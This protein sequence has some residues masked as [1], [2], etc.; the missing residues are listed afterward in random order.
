MSLAEILKWRLN[1]GHP[2]D[3]FHLRETRGL[4]I[5]LLVEGSRTLT[6]VGVEWD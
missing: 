2:A 1:R 4:E 5:D 6:P 3:L